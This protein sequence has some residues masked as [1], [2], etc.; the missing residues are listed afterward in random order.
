[1]NLAGSVAVWYANYDI[2]INY[3]NGYLLD[4][5]S[6]VTWDIIRVSS[7]TWS[8]HEDQWATLTSHEV[9]ENDLATLTS[10]EDSLAK[11]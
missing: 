10:H 2:T 7:E 3:T 8:S 4:Y 5:I 1:M 11:L 6:A 9:H